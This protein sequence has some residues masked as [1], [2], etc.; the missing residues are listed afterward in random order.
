MEPTESITLLSTVP[1]NGGAPSREG[2]PLQQLYKPDSVKG[3]HPSTAIRCRTAHAA[4]PEAQASSLRALPY[5][6]LHRVGLAW[7]PCHHG[8]GAL[9][10]HHFTFAA[11]RTPVCC[12]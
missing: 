9:L 7:P 5:S 10:P 6:A 1:R 3:N 11:G 12:V 4:N 2:A 8:A